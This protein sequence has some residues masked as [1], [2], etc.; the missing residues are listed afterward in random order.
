VYALANGMS[1]VHFYSGSGDT[2]VGSWNLATGTF[3]KPIAKTNTAI[4]AITGDVSSQ[5]LYIGQR[6]G[7]LYKA[8]LHRISP[9]KAIEAHKGDIYGIEL[10]GARNRVYS[11]GADGYLRVWAMDTL[12]LLGA[13][14]LCNSNV[15]C[16]VL[17]PEKGQLAIGCSDGSLRI[18]DAET[19]Q[20]KHL[21][22]AH[23][24]SVFT[25]CWLNENQMLSGG[26]DALLKRWEL[27]DNEWEIKQ[28][29]PAHLYT[30]NHLALS[31][32]KKHLASASRDK[33]IKI[34]DINTLNLLKVLDLGKFEAAHTHS[35][36]RV[37]WADEEQLLSAGDDKKILGWII[38]D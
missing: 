11:C 36:N 10:D 15:R 37:L 4:Y 5:F 24:P 13:F 17:S 27:I 31:P 22:L 8:D 33:T 34:W 26:R 25:V 1:P 12:A 38:K 32:D 19:L 2:F 30:I 7:V 21:L 28:S 20:Q 9:I 29:I 35:V 23:D 18:F 6:G 16:A 3:E 14:H